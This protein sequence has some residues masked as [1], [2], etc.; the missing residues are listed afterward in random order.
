ME[1]WQFLPFCF[2]CK[3][4][5]NCIRNFISQS[6]PIKI[7]IFHN[8]LPEYIYKF[9]SI[10]WRCKL[11]QRP[12]SRS[13]SQVR[14]VTALL[15]RS[16]LWIGTRGVYIHRR[17]PVVSSGKLGSR[18]GAHY[19]CG[20]SLLHRLLLRMLGVLRLHLFFPHLL[21]HRDNDHSNYPKGR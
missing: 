3:N 2:S 18:R 7:L 20:T 17:L 15:C 11:N 1:F 14:Y 5:K 8:S 10:G 4:C 9:F 19:S 16:I 6:D 12:L 13:L 21:D